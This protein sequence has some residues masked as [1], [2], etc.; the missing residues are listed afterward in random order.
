MYENSNKTSLAVLI[1][2]VPLFVIFMAWLLPRTSSY[3]SFIVERVESVQ[4][5]R[6]YE[7]HTRMVFDPVGYL[8]GGIPFRQS[9]P[10]WLIDNSA[11]VD[12]DEIP[13]CGEV[14]DPQIGDKCEAVVTEYL[15]FLEGEANTWQTSELLQIGDVITLELM[16]DGTFAR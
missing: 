4:I 14:A 9:S 7:Y 5:P 8:S 6:L 16:P 12:G 10:D 1:I 13:S 11:I 15:V 2:T 3:G